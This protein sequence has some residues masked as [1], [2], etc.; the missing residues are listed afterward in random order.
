[1]NEIRR[2]LESLD[3]VDD[4]HDLHVWTLTSGIDIASAHLRLDDRDDQQVAF[5]RAR[6][7]LDGFG[8]SHAT[9][10]VEHSSS[11]AEICSEEN[12]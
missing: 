11:A 10:Q 12:W 7:V 4:A 5:R 8:I 3:G 6:E 2:K 9:V 1:M